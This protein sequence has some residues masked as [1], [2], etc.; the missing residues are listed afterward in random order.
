MLVSSGSSENR[1][2]T[3]MTML[4]QVPQLL[5]DWKFQISR[6]EDNS[7]WKSILDLLK[8]NAFL[9]YSEKNCQYREFIL[10]G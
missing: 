3:N 8:N 5:V 9:M 1:Y 7:G 2:E 4:S 6:T 10:S